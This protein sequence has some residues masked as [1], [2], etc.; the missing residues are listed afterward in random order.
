M[1]LEIYE[2]ER[3]IIMGQWG[4]I[5][6]II[7]FYSWLEGK[8]SIWLLWNWNGYF[9]NKKQSDEYYYFFLSKKK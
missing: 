8:F 2:G 6:E 7:S 1:G 5:W 3:E 9:F 4:N